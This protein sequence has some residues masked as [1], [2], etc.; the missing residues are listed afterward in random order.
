MIINYCIPYKPKTLIYK[1]I[2]K[3]IHI[4]NVGE[5]ATTRSGVFEVIEKPKI[6]NNRKYYS[7]CNLIKKTNEEEKF[8][9]IKKCQNDFY[10]GE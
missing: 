8:C 1:I 4:S 2:N 7:M 5:K 9:T 10:K 6:C 3:E